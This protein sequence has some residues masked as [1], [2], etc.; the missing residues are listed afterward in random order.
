MENIINKSKANLIA[1]R[2]H[3]A[4][5]RLE[6]LNRYMQRHPG[7]KKTLEFDSRDDA[8]ALL[9]ANPKTWFRLSDE[10]K[11]DPTMVYYLQPMGLLNVELTHYNQIGDGC[12]QIYHDAKWGEVFSQF[13]FNLDEKTRYQI[14]AFKLPEGF[15]VEK[16][17]AIQTELLASPIVVDDDYDRFHSIIGDFN[18][19]AC[20]S[21]NNI[22]W[23]IKNILLFDRTLIPELV[24]KHV[25]EAQHR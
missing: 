19:S 12:I 23:S 8:I 24:K 21:D 25:I 13:Y 14:P 5:S 18:K 4:E 9:L 6:F 3:D 1:K 2:Y 17:I 7:E 16:Y 15:D 22:S 11:N 10:L 20:N